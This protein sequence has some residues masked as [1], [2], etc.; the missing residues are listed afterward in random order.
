MFFMTWFVDGNG[1][2]LRE[3]KEWI[4]GYPKSSPCY[5]VSVPPVHDVIS[6]L[7]VCALG[8]VKL[9]DAL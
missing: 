7:K 4:S 6:G 1:R 5:Q 3:L 8:L 2:E 9:G